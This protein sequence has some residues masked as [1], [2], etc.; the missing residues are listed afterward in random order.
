MITGLLVGAAASLLIPHLGSV[1]ALAALWGLETIGYT[2]SNPAQMAFIADIAGKD[3]R[4]TSYGMYTFA[5]FLGAAIGPL[6]GGWLYDNVGHAMLFYLN[7]AVLFFGAI[8]IGAVL[9][10]PKKKSLE[11]Q[12]PNI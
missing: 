12:F 9:R 3:F 1:I 6:L 5:F 8:I 4:G 10:E 11:T 2:V 7:T